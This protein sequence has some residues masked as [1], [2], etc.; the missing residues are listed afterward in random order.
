M[1]RTNENSHLICKYIAK[2]IHKHDASQ[3][4]MEKTFNSKKYFVP[5]FT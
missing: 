5:F 2:S 1:L 4:K 3:Q